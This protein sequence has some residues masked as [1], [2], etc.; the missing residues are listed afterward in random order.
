MNMKKEE[1]TRAVYLA[2]LGELLH[3]EPPMNEIPFRGRP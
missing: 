1:N 3:L 2:I